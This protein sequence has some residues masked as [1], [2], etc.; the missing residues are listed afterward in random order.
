VH[1]EQSL[2]H[3]KLS[4]AQRLTGVVVADFVLRKLVENIAGGYVDQVVAVHRLLDDVVSERFYGK[5]RT[6]RCA[7]RDREQGRI[8]KQAYEERHCRGN[9]R[10]N[11]RV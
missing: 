1:A 11:D 7:E 8:D 9:G 4:E 2:Q 5:Q 6:Q 3:K 10:G